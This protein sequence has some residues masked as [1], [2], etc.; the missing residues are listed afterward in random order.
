ML[1]RRAIWGKSTMYE[2]SVRVPLLLAGPGIAA[3]RR[4]DPVSLI[5]LAPTITE[6]AGL[7]DPMRGFAGRSLLASPAPDRTVLSEYHDGGSPVG[8]TVV[9][10]GTWK[11]VH[12]AE[13][14]P[15]ELFDLAEDPDEQENLAGERPNIVAEAHRRMA[16]FLD[17][18]EVNARAH[19][20]QACLVE[21]LGG[22][23]KL[24]AQPQWNF[25]PADSR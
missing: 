5:D 1:G 8:I 17:P 9:R 10:W 14:H 3:G 15:P 16:E 20:D 19:A 25:T 18:E 6:A 13:G 12:Y 24:L 7:A 11:Y 4:D 23:E 2:D 21:Q 22:R